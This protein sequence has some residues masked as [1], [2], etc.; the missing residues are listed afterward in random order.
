M[1][2]YLSKNQRKRK[3]IVLTFIVGFIFSIFFK[4][5]FNT[6]WKTFLSDVLFC[7]S[8]V[9]FL[10][11]FCE[12]VLKV[13]FFNGPTYGTRK[14][15]DILKSN[16]ASS[17]YLKEDYLDYVRSQQNK[18][19]DILLLISVGLLFLILSILIYFVILQI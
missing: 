18:E 1:Q 19:Y 3:K 6:G 4:Y 14:L 10:R 12:L 17:D 8:M 9:F 13:G 11:G 7:I 16:F 2:N 15:M 5:N